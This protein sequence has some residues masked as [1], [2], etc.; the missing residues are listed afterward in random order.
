MLN[1]NRCRGSRGFVELRRTLT[2]GDHDDASPGGILGIVNV[3]V[4][5]LGLAS[6]HRYA[7][8]LDHS[9]PVGIEVVETP[10]FFSVKDSE[11]EWERGIRRIHDLV[12]RRHETDLGKATPKFCVARAEFGILER[13]A[14]S[15]G[16]SLPILD[17]FLDV[18][19][20]WAIAGIVATSREQRTN[21]KDDGAG[22]DH[23][24]PWNPC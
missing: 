13:A 18:S 24:D 17:L 6:E 16:V 19:S 21:E 8:P 9:I 1:A 23:R 11:G 15:L 7:L 12:R 10:S 3:H 20:G 22:D 14:L 4:S 2:I 5:A